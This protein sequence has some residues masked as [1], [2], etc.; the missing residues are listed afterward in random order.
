MIL[1]QSVVYGGV[2]ADVR[3]FEAIAGEP[4]REQARDGALYAVVLVPIDLLVSNVHIL[5]D[6]PLRWCAG[7]GAGDRGSADLGG[8]KAY[9]PVGT[10][11]IRPGA[12]LFGADRYCYGS[13]CPP[14]GYCDIRASERAYYL[15]SWI[16]TSENI[17]FPT[18]GE[19]S[20][21]KMS[22]PLQI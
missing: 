6:D 8:T 4:A 22:I 7:P 13:Y 18:L 1:E 21:H 20:S 17:P 19:L 14:K 9:R 15:T 2:A 10:K 12:S 5:C 3:V 16:R 11:C